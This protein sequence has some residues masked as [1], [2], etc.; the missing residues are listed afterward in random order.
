LDIS[1]SLWLSFY[2]PE[3]LGADERLASRSTRRLT[4]AAM[5]RGGRPRTA[6]SLLGFLPDQA[7]L[8]KVYT[9]NYENVM[10]TKV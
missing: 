1:I 5:C 3:P 6:Q 2:N 8:V 4:L 9:P 7:R 10:L